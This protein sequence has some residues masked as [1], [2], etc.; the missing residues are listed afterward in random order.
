MSSYDQILQDYCSP[1]SPVI[2]LTN[3]DDTLLHIDSKEMRILE[4][5]KQKN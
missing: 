3:T 5:F 4:P 2:W 1:F